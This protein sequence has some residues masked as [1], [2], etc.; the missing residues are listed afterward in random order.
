MTN[1]TDAVPEF[2]LKDTRAIDGAVGPRSE[3]ESSFIVFLAS[4][5]F[6]YIHLLG[7]PTC[8]HRFQ[9]RSPQTQPDRLSQLCLCSLFHMDPHTS[10]YFSLYISPFIF[11]ASV[12][13]HPFVRPPHLAPNVQHSTRNQHTHT[14]LMTSPDPIHSSNPSTHRHVP[15]LHLRLPSFMYNTVPPYPFYL[16]PLFYPPILTRLFSLFIY[17]VHIMYIVLGSYRRLVHEA[18]T[19]ALRRVS[20]NQ[21]LYRIYQW[22]MRLYLKLIIFSQ[23]PSGRLHKCVLKLFQHLQC[24]FPITHFQRHPRVRE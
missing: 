24:C 19:L 22:Y 3:D 5:L 10:T 23:W 7:F 11:T 13:R 2:K 14:S 9:R 18:S 17:Y 8:T 12:I 6:L 16:P 21:N 15:D 1:H 4:S 20:P